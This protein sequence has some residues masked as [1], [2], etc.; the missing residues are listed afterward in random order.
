MATQRNDTGRNATLADRHKSGERSSPQAAKRSTKAL[1][2]KGADAYN[3]AAHEI[4]DALGASKDQLQ[5]AVEKADAKRAPKGAERPPEP[6]RPP[7]PEHTAT[8]PLVPT[9]RITDAEREYALRL[10]WQGIA[11]QLR[12]PFPP[13]DIEWRLQQVGVKDNKPWAKAIA[14]LT[15][16]AIQDRLD[17]IVGPGNWK[18]YFQRGPEGGVMCGIGI[19]IADDE[20]VFK[21]DGAGN[22]KTSD[23]LSEGDAIKGGFSNAM[24]RAAVQWGIGRYL[25]GLTDSFVNIHNGG[26][27][28]QGPKTTKKGD[29]VPPFH[30]DPPKLPSWALPE[31]PEPEARERERPLPRSAEQTSARTSAAANSTAR[32][33]A[34]PAGQTSGASTATSAAPSATGSPTPASTASR[35]KPNAAPGSAAALIA[36]ID[37]LVLQMA[38]AKHPRTDEVRERVKRR[39]IEHP[40]NTE[41]LTEI[42]DAVKH[43]YAQHVGDAADDTEGDTAA[44][45]AQ[46]STSSASARAPAAKK[47]AAKKGAAA[48]PSPTAAASPASSAAADSR[49]DLDAIPMRDHLGTAITPACPVC[50]QMMSDERGLKAAGKHKPNAPDFRC[51]NPTCTGAFWPNQFQVEFA[52]G[53]FDGRPIFGLANGNWIK[54]RIHR[55]PSGMPVAL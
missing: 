15:Q 12:A 52:R 25:Y 41:K 16:R 19:R 51:D 3:A 37:G 46:P 36:E 39:K 21:Y 40:N 31:P 5:D 44:T 43:L 20:W 8:G 45:A 32:S 14:Y 11:A 38:K 7:R 23:G 47:A 35:A 28:Y 50:E 34:R 27:K 29:N 42:R 9:P 17:E 49:V 24:K 18:N 48:H 22:P 30:W 2:G 55:T 53:D 54:A 26:A 6:E 1:E 10:F 13:D 4:V 33:E